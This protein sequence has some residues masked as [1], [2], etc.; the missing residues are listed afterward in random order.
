[1]IDYYSI[2][3][4]SNSRLGLVKSIIDGMPLMKAKESTLEF[5]KQLH[6][7]VLEPEKYFFNLASDKSFY[8]KYKDKVSAMTAGARGN[9]LVS[10]FLNNPLT[11]KEEDVFF[12]HERSGLECKLKADI[13]SERTIGDLKTTS[14]TTK[15]EFEATI[16]KYG[17][18]RQGAFYLDATG[19]KEF[20]LIGIS[21]KYPHH[22]FTTSLKDTDERIISGRAEY[23]YLLD[24]YIRLKN[25]GIDFIELM[26]AS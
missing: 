3:R 20:I 24:E 12:T 4:V 13:I 19:A 17:Y 8:K 1:M 11:K 5:G 6:E 25:E 14:C 15:A 21:K 26:K 9:L 16:L 18:H 23:E 10:F 2:D 7:S 22:T